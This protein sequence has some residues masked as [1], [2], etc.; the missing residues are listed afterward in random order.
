[1]TPNPKLDLCV[2]S[3]QRRD[4]VGGPDNEEDNDCR[5]ETHS[6]LQARRGDIFSYRTCSFLSSLV[7]RHFK[8]NPEDVF[9]VSFC[10]KQSK[11]VVYV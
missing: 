8:G 11:E 3:G 10:Y 1:M 4:A 6:T 2:S 5:R 7:S 9:V